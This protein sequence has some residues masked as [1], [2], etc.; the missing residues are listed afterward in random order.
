MKQLA[1]VLFARD[2]NPQKYEALCRVLS[3]TYCRTGSPTDLLQLYLSVFT[4]GSCAGQDNGTFASDEYTGRRA[5]NNTNVRGLIK[6]FELKTILIYTAILLK[7]RII[8]YHH[9][10]E[11]L[12]RWIQTFPAFMKHRNVTENLFPWVDLVKDEVLEL[13]VLIFQ[14]F[15]SFKAR[16]ELLILIFI[17]SC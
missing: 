9:S 8:V 3:K 4:K 12:L 7:K 13:K 14:S 15:E 6:A 1:L 5:G 2:F 17:V 16:L 10:L 11:Q